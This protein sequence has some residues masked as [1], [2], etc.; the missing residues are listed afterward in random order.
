[1]VTRSFVL[2]IGSNL[3]DRLACLQGAVDAL[4]TADGITVTSVSRVY[5]T[6]PVGGPE[7]PDYFNAVVAGSTTLEP[8]HL[9]AFAQGVELDW[10]RTR[11]IR[12][13]ARTLDIDVIAMGDFVSDD[14]LLTVP[15][16]RAGERAFVLVPW[17]EIE[18]SAEL[19][20][21]GAIGRILE[22]LDASGVRET[23]LTLA[24]TA[25]EGAP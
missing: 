9:L 21:M 19:P 2:S 23:G 17:R 25:P 18:P 15:H 13:G 3:G 10:D 20:G 8:A 6:D 16:P 22:G 5:E 7:Q 1:M 12:W 11:E 4:A 14:P 24:L